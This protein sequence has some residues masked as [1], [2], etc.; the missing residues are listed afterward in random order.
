MAEYG[1]IIIA[2]IWM[3]ISLFVSRTQISVATALIISQ[4]WLVMWYFVVHIYQGS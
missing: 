2:F 3:L 1:L 4:I